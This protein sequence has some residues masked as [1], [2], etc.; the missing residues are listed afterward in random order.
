MALNLKFSVQI[1]SWY[2]ICNKNKR[3]QCLD[4]RNFKIYLNLSE[5]LLSA[6]IKGIFFSF[7]FLEYR[8]CTPFYLQ[9][10]TTA[11]SSLFILRIWVNID[12]VSK[13]KL[14]GDVD[15]G[16]SRWGLPSLVFGKAWE[17][18]QLP[19]SKQV[20]EKWA[21]EALTAVMN[22]TWYLSLLKY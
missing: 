3:V 6:S 15:L 22:S 1:E 10:F 16:S 18:Q 13:C 8:F 4:H 7:S 11:T 17:E 21:C 5:C 20:W 14:R 12:S 9:R 19:K 2:F